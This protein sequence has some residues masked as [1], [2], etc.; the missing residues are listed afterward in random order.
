M[1]LNCNNCG[2]CFIREKRQL[3]R[4]L[5]NKESNVYCSMKC[6]TDHSITRLKVCLTCNKS[7]ITGQKKFCSKSCSASYNNKNKT[8]GTR[9]SKLE[10]YVQ[11][12]LSLLY[13]KLKI[14]YNN[15][16]IIKSELD[17]YIPE[18]KL[19]FE[20][21]GI[22]HYKDIFGEKK[23]NNIKLNDL[24]KINKCLELNIEL[25]I[26]NSSKLLY[27]KISNFEI[28]LNL[29]KSKIENYTVAK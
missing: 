12:Q 15:K 7:L 25:V 27:N 17:I 9:I 13:P 20:I 26:I 29:I 5:K 11:Q 23:L 10:I 14:A 19:A 18:L 8:K 1:E 24:N 2:N 6:K 16:E 28:Y 21:N 22:F 4:Y 3:Y